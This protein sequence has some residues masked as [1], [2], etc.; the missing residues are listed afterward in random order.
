MLGKKVKKKKKK[1][2]TKGGGKRCSQPAGL[3]SATS[4]GFVCI[5]LCTG[6]PEKLRAGTHAG[7]CGTGA[8]EVGQ[9][10]TISPDHCFPGSARDRDAGRALPR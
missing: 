3:R 1:Q 5:S 8:M 2:A 7:I 10:R 9:P 4:L 6:F